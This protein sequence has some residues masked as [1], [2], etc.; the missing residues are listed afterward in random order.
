MKQEHIKYLI[1][2]RLLRK[3]LKDIPR[4]KSLIESSQNNAEVTKSI[5]I[6][7]KSATLIFREIYESIRQLGD[8]K[9]WLLDYES[10]SH[11]SSMEILTEEEIKDKISLNKLYRFK[12]MR[13][14][15]N[16][17]GYKV[18]VEQAKEIVDFW[19]SCGEELIKKIKKEL[20]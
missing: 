17:R 7:E 1:E 2:K 5:K 20:P 14:D 13:N 4:I 6:N 16:Y 9:W 12:R 10:M 8:A 3:R 19:N 11:E 15:A 18:T